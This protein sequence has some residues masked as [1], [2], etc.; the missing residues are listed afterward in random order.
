M[1]H[2][3]EKL[4]K[5]L[6]EEG[7][8]SAGYDYIVKDFMVFI[9]GRDIGIRKKDSEIYSYIKL[10][11]DEEDLL[12]KA[13]DVCMKRSEDYMINAIENLL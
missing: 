4:A 3:V 12:K 2:W 6:E 10:Y 11:E 5:S 9:S 1:R 8:S 13:T 7:Y